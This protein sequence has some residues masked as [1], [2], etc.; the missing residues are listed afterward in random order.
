MLASAEHGEIAVG[1]TQRVLLIVLMGCTAVGVGVLALLPNRSASAEPDGG[2]IEVPDHPTV[3]QASAAVLAPGTA[4]GEP[5]M[6]ASDQPHT[7][8]QRLSKRGLHPPGSPGRERELLLAELATIEAANDRTPNFIYDSALRLSI[9]VILDHQHRA[10]RWPVDPTTLTRSQRTVNRNGVDYI[11]EMTEF[12]EIDRV[13]GS[14]VAAPM[15]WAE[16]QPLVR[17][18]IVEALALVPPESR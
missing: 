15:D 17:K 13:S 9:T 16:I 4:E 6:T 18:R 14:P 5:N 1:T 8:P 3:L 11:F 10:A 12:P 2:A 7:T